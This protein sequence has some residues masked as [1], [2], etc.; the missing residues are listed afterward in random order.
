[1]TLESEETNLEELTQKV[2]DFII[3]LFRLNI[4]RGGSGRMDCPACG[5]KGSISYYRV[6]YNGHI[7]AECTGCKI[8]MMQ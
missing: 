2:N 6:P 1:M 7:H 8:R 5:G 3:A 4:P